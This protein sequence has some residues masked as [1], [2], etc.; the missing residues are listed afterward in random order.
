MCIYMSLIFE[1]NELLFFFFCCCCCLWSK[2]YDIDKCV[3][4][5][6]SVLL[7]YPFLI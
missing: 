7:L 3:R 6:T 2:L 4:V 5:G 1:M